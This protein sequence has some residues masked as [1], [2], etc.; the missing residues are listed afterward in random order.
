MSTDRTRLQPAGT[1]HAGMPL[2]P[3]RSPWLRR[4]GVLVAALCLAGLGVWA[5]AQRG[6]DD[7]SEALAELAGRVAALDQ[8]VARERQERAAL[9]REVARL[10]AALEQERPREGLAPPAPSAL[11][12]Q[13][14]PAISPAREAPVAGEVSAPAPH[15]ARFDERRLRDSGIAASEIERYRARLAEIE[16]DRLH[17]RDRA[18][19]EGWLD[20][21]RF[22]EESQGIDAALAGLDGEFDDEVHD[23]MRY[24][25]G[26]PNRL[27]VTE[28]LPGSAAETAGVQRGDL[29]LRYDGERLLAAEALRDATAG[30]VAGAW[31]DLEVQRGA[32]TLRLL[33][34]RGPLGV[35]IDARSIAPSRSGD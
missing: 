5:G 1:R 7:P 22:A 6:A 29:L 15:A 14:P 9:A 11:P 24:A 3:Q 10:Q 12:A 20:T 32:E 33:V 4:L 19:R 28:V 21:P 34:P 13:P 25:A 27:A 26:Q 23:W 2:R 17:L 31:A 18:A 35:A 8:T 30:G 16:L